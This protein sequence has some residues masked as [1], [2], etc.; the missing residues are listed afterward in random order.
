MSNNAFDNKMPRQAA[1]VARNISYSS[2]A[3]GVEASG[4]FDILKSVGQ[5]ALP[6]AS[7]LLGAR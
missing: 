6:I 4:F 2:M 1:P 3:N 5:V 7:Q